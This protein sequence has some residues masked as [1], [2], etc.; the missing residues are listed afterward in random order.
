[1]AKQRGMTT[2]PSIPYVLPT[3]LRMD[4]AHILNLPWNLALHHEWISASL[5]IDSVTSEKILPLT[6]QGFGGPSKHEP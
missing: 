4:S 2:A 5:I 3:L 1:M 6:A